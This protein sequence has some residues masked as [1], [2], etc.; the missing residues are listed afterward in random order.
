MLS[1]LELVLGVDNIIFISLIIS[2]LPQKERTSVRITALALAIVMRIGLLWGIV[3]LSK[4]TETLFKI[5]DFSVSIRDI[6]YLGGGAFLCWSTF[7]EM[8]NHLLGKAGDKSKS[9]EETTPVH[10]KARNIIARVVL[11][12]VL[13]SFD[14]IF[15]AIGLSQNFIVMASAVA[16]GVSC[17]FWLSGKIAAY[18]D[19]RPTMKTVAFAFI[20]VVALNLVLNTFHVEIPRVWLYL[21]FGLALAVELYNILSG[22]RTTEKS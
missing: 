10:S 22:K 5:S 21:A 1:G 3:A 19:K 4:I 17:M 2:K 13:F 6:L 8:R 16:I 7:F 9:E 18:I 15:T 12:D 20:L 11:V 14:S